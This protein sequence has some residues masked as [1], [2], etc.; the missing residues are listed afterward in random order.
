MD[1]VTGRHGDE[2]GEIGSH[3]EDEAVVGDLAPQAPSHAGGGELEEEK[4]TVKRKRQNFEKGEAQ[5]SNKR[6]R[7]VASAEKEER[8]PQLSLDSCESSDNCGSKRRRVLDKKEDCFE[9]TNSY[10]EK[11]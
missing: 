1:T 5:W 8:Q 2:T 11:A 10:E 6:C 9:D 7:T 4:T 3:G